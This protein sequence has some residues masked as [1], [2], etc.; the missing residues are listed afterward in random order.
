MGDLLIVTI[1]PDC[2]VD[3]GPNRPAFP[4]NIRAEAVASQL[5]VD[6][7]A[8][9]KW[10]TAEETIRLLRPHV[11][12][13]GS[14][15]KGADSDLTG[16]LTR[17]AQVVGEIGGRLAFTQDMVF[18]STNLINR[19]FSTFP[20]DVQEYLEVFRTRYR[21]EDLFRLLDDMSSLKVLVIGDTILDD[22]QYCHTIGSSSKDPVLAVQYDSHDL[23]AGG[24]LA[25]ANHISNFVEEVKLVTLLGERDSHE[26][27]IRS[28]LHE[29]V[30]P[31][32]V[33]Q[34]KAP[35]LIKRRFIEGYSL[36]KLFEV[37]V[38]DDSG[39]SEEKD[40]ELSDWLKS[41]LPQY[42]LAIAADFGHGAIS[43]R[44]RQ[45]LVDH[46]PFCGR[47]HPGKLWK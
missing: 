14:D 21:P 38:M 41:N 19:F 29:N 28:R 47:Q 45:T 7:V 24:V 15:F 22:Y 46:A 3:K 44:S 37:Y 43:R 42:D 40:R 25:V 1:T 13:K 39:L 35:T 2:F 16:K 20:K 27:F 32:F 8:I 18:S 11:Y 17:E 36:N 31:F 12:V 6:Y 30:S 5:G 10:P 4:E 9:N 34:E 23:F 33:T 26:E